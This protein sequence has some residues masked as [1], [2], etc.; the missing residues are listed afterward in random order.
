MG[1]LK[2]T[3]CD[4]EEHRVQAYNEV[5]RAITRSVRVQPSIAITRSDAELL[6]ITVSIPSDL[7]NC[8]PVGKSNPPQWTESP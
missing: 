5:V 1:V 7:P 3:E 8:C 2:N 6:L 4:V